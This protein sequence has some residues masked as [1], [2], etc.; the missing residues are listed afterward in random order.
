[1]EKS[2]GAVA[3]GFYADIVAV[4]HLAFDIG[5]VFGDRALIHLGWRGGGL[6]RRW[7]CRLRCAPS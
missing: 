4:R 2:L 5:D 6:R 7:R 1:M 3:P